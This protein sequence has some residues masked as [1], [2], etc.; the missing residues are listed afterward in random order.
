MITGGQKQTSVWAAN[1]TR[2][3]AGGRARR[4]EEGGGGGGGDDGMAAGERGRVGEMAGI[5]SH[6]R[7]SEE[8]EELA[9]RCVVR[10][11]PPLSAERQA[12]T[13]G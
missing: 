13:V 1:N 9:S 5:R 6:G 10:A 4:R 12:S 3:Q 2:E 7:A 11:T 8:Q